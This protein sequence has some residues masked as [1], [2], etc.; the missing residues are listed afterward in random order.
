MQSHAAGASPPPLAQLVRQLAARNEDAA[1]YSQAI[2]WFSQ[3]A[4]NEAQREPIIN[5]GAIP[6]LLA[7]IDE[8]PSSRGGAAGSGAGS[9]AGGGSRGSGAGGLAGD[10]ISMLRAKALRTLGYLASTPS[11]RPRLAELGLLAALVRALCSRPHPRVRTNA[12]FAL[13][14]LLLDQRLAASLSAEVLPP[15]VELLRSGTE[16]DQV[17]ER[18]PT[19]PRVRAARAFWERSSSSGRAA[20]RTRAFSRDVARPGRMPPCPPP[21]PQRVPAPLSSPLPS[22]PK[23]TRTKMPLRPHDARTAPTHRSTPR[24]SSRP[25]SARAARSTRRWS[26]AAARASS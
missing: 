6:L 23:P 10:D 26:S 7:A 17:R 11:L 25:P 14:Q 20:V 15:L 12:A 24:A 22:T 9:S 13:A 8:Q 3:L 5:S 18:P 2:Q 1:A 4:T 16:T 21:E 19:R